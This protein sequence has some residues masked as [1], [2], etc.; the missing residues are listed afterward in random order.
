VRGPVR[1]DPFPGRD[2]ARESTGP[3]RD[4]PAG[5]FGSG[6]EERFPADRLPPPAGE[7]F[8]EQFAPEAGRPENPPATQP[9]A[10]PLPE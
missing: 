5:P 6:P 7:R 4:A 8:G 3:Y 10:A 1:D 2:P 9:V